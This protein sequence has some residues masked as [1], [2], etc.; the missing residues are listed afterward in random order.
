MLKNIT[1]I[2]LLGIFLSPILISCSSHQHQEENI[3]HYTCPM[4]PKIKKDNPGQCPICGMNL[5]P[6]KK[7]GDSSKKSH[8]GQVSINPRYIQ[9]IGVVTAEVKIRE[10]VHTI[11]T[12]GKIAHDHK[13][14]I[15]QKEYLES[16]KLKDSSLIE[17]AKQKLLFLGL[18]ESWIKALEKN[19]SADLDLHLKTDSSKPKYIEAYVYQED[20]KSIKEG[21][22][23]VISDQKGRHLSHG[24]IKAIGTLVDLNSRAVRVLIESNQPLDLKL[25][26]FVQIKIEVPL[27]ESL[28]IPKD[29]VLFNGNHNMVYVDQGSGQYQ[30]RKIEIGI[31]A[32]NYY[33]IKEGLTN[34]D[35]VVVNGHFLI[36][37]ESQIKGQG[38]NHQH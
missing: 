30:G 11:P 9:N 26:T 3:T 34:Q 18:S 1:F 28:S 35:K 13:L 29:A 25:N 32:G 6:V 5:T 2:I 12:Y 15:A 17:A 20:I 33:Q 27:G 31:E 38:I 22:K 4:H 8:Q 23:V 16:L 21:L 10:L 14:W 36:D 7:E 37:S 19:K 24:S